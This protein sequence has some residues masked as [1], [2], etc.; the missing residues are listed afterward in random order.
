LLFNDL[1]WTKCFPKVVFSLKGAVSLM[2]PI[3]SPS[4]FNT[5]TS[6]VIIIISGFVC[7]NKKLGLAVAR[8]INRIN[9]ADFIGWNKS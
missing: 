3:E 1:R 8:A 7:P 9:T 2:I 5:A 4:K 6:F